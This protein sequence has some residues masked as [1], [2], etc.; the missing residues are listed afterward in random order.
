MDADAVNKK[1]CPC[2]GGFHLEVDPPTEASQLIDDLTARIILTDKSRRIIV[3]TID[4]WYAINRLWI[5]EELR[6]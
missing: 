1:R 6:D 4:E 2:C 5:N 3:P